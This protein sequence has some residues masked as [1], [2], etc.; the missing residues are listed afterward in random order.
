MHYYEVLIPVGVGAGMAY[1]PS[2]DEHHW[3]YRGP[4]PFPLQPPHHQPPPHMP[5]GMGLVSILTPPPR[6]PMPAPYGFAPNANGVN[7]TSPPMM[8]AP[9]D[10]LVP[11]M[12]LPR[13]IFFSVL[14][15][16][17]SFSFYLDIFTLSTPYCVTSFPSSPSPSQLPNCHHGTTE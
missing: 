12:L 9:N 10:I 8:F 4:P 13:A 11:G 3:G 14:F 2:N 1:I 15:F 5:R 6:N 16:F 7:A 17:V